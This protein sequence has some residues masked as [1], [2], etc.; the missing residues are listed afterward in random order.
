[1]PEFVPA[2]RERLHYKFAQFLR[3]LHPTARLYPPPP[4]LPASSANS[5]ATHINSALHAL[6]TAARAHQQL[7]L[8][9][10]VTAL[11]PLPSP[12]L[13]GVAAVSISRSVDEGY[14][15][16]ELWPTL[17]RGALHVLETAYGKSAAAV[18]GLTP[19]GVAVEYARG[20]GPVKEDPLDNLGQ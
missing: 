16:L 1:M 4:Q 15:P 14:V 13:P 18:N 2:S 17:E 5:T 3:A 20:L 9:A 7:Q 10:Q 8:L 6:S 11:P 19:P 12:V